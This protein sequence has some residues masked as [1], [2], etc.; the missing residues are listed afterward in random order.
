MSEDQCFLSQTAQH[1]RDQSRRLILAGALAFVAGNLLYA[2][3]PGQIA[4]LR[5]SF[6]IGLFYALVVVI[7]A[8]FITG[9][10]PRQRRLVDAVAL[11]RLGFALF[12]VAAPETGQPLVF[13]PF[14]SATIV[15]G[16]ALLLSTACPVL[17]AICCRE[18]MP[19]VIR[20]CAERAQAAWVWVDRDKA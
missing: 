15:V 17:H 20:R 13:S 19:T 4:G 5:V 6:W 14:Y 3:M 12:V 2:H 18:G 1:L 7:G 11:S 16:T 10:F 9:Y 8:M